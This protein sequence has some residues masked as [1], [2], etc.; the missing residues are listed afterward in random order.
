MDAFSYKI[1]AK[2]F[3]PKKVFLKK[4]FIFQKICFKVKVLKTFKSS[5]GCHIKT[6]QS[7]K[8]RAILKISSTVF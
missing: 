5:S 4:V 1:F 6:C 3:V 7:L 8:C 2:Y